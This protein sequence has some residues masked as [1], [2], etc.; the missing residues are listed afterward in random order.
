MKYDILSGKC[1]DVM[2]SPTDAPIE[3]SSNSDN[4]DNLREE[5]T[6]VWE[7]N[8]EDETSNPTVTITVSDA[9][10]FI[11]DVVITGTTNVEAVKITVIDESGNEVSI[12]VYITTEIC[13]SEPHIM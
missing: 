12:S 1:D 7:S 8:P 5:D 10:S 9:D 3:A 11:D 6:D 4:V 2:S 13:Q